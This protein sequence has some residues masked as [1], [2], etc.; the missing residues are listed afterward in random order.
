MPNTGK[1]DQLKPGARVVIHTAAGGCYNKKTGT[2]CHVL[3]S[4]MTPI[5]TL[6][7]NAVDKSPYWYRVRFDTPANN[8][9][10]PV[11]MDIFQANELQILA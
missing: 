3:N 10:V 8:G 7:N 1:L 2:I 11:H 9:G 6:P 5:D 4:G